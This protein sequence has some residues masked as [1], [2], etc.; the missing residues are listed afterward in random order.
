MT[1][2]QIRRAQSLKPTPSSDVMEKNSSQLQSL[3]RRLERL[4]FAGLILTGL[5]FSEMYLTAANAQYAED[6]TFVAISDMIIS[7]Q[8]NITTL[9][10]MFKSYRYDAEAIDKRKASIA[11]TRK[12]LGLKDENTQEPSHQKNKTE[13]PKTYKDYLNMLIA[14]SVEKSNCSPRALLPYNDP[15]TPPDEIISKLQSVKSEYDKKPFDIWGIKSPR[16]IGIDYA[17]ANF[18]FQYNFISTSLFFIL[19]ILISGWLSSFYITRQREMH[20]IS[21]S[22]N[23]GDIFPHLLNFIP[24]HF[25][26]IQPELAQNNKTLIKIT[27]SVLRTFLIATI[28]TPMVIAHAYSII[29][30]WT[31]DYLKSVIIVFLLYATIQSLAIIYQEPVILWRTY[32]VEK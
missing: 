13:M 20:Q 16:S 4:T 7:M 26:A 14:E 29:H 11:A 15:S 27:L 23:F 3:G 28:V 12:E 17:G 18:Q 19:S 21:K 24:V 9:E 5:S 8:S 31:N 30:F 25:E 22:R 1:P 10:T 2:L 32:F 6:K